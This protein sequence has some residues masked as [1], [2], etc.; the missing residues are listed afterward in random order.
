MDG[1]FKM[2]PDGFKQLFTINGFVS[3]IGESNGAMKQLPFFF[4]FMRCRKAIDYQAIFEAIRELMGVYKLTDVVCDFEKGVWKAVKNVFPG[5]DVFGCNFHWKQAVMRKSRNFGLA[6]SYS[7][8]GSF[9]R[10]VIQNLLCLCYLPSSDIALEFASIEVLVNSRKHIN[11]TKLV[12]Y[13]RN[14][15]IDDRQMGP[16]SWSVYNRA[17]RTNNDCEGLHNRWNRRSRD[18][19]N[20]YWIL[21]VIGNETKNVSR[22]LELLHYGVITRKQ[23]QASVEHQKGLFHLWCQ[24]TTNSWSSS[25]LLQRVVEFMAPDLP[26]SDQLHDIQEYPSPLDIEEDFDPYC[27]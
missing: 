17:I 19:R 2:A 14:V 23:R 7:K 3:T 27:T 18:R 20:F 13:V 22:N 11:L 1:T 9:E 16:S 25:M 26:R 21:S 12:T 10:E 8:R 24:H 5:V 4:S 15:W 6:S